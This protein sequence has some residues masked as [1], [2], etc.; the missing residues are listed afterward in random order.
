V[1]FRAWKEETY[2]LMSI[3]QTRAAVHHD[4]PCFL[5]KKVFVVK[6]TGTNTKTDMANASGKKH[7]FQPPV[8]MIG[9]RKA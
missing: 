2:L 5:R 7:L 6:D 9:S 3:F 8:N 4:S 1:P